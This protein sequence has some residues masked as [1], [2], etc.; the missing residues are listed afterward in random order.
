MPGDIWQKFANLRLLFGF[1]FTHPG[2]KLLFMGMEIA[3]WNE[4]HHETSIE[5]HLLD[6]DTH[7]KLQAWVRDLNMFYRNDRPLH[8]KDFTNDGFRWVDCSNNEDSVISYIRMGSDPDDVTLVVCNFTPV[9]RHR[10]RIGVPFDCRWREALNS[11]A[12]EYGGGGVG[13]EGGADP[14]PV[15]YHGFYDSLSLTLPPLGVLVLKPERSP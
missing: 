10:Y 4:W 1:M 7:S 13:N 2:K 6:F 8:E 11:D 12:L 14:T 9:P 15:P 3:Q 5:W